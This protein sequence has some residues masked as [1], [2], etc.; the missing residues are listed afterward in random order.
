M[1][2]IIIQINKHKDT[3]KN[4][5]VKLTNITDQKVLNTLPNFTKLDKQRI[6]NN[7]NIIRNYK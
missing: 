5:N 1:V 4:L 7:N 6:V 3:I 2:E